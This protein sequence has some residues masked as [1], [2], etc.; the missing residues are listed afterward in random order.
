MELCGERLPPVVTMCLAFSASTLISVCERS[1]L[2][3]HCFSKLIPFVNCEK[4]SVQLFSLSAVALYTSTL[5]G[6]VGPCA[7]VVARNRLA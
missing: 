6:F 2:I 4:L 7:F 5:V 1:V 3:M